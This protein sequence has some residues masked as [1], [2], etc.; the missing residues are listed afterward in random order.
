MSKQVAE[1]LK[2]LFQM[3]EMTRDDEVD[4][5]AVYDVMDE[6]AELASSG[7]DI[8]NLMPE[9]DDHLQR[10]KACKEELG[11]LQTIVAEATA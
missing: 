8:A 5:T 2:M 1:K 9:I 3:L 7:K 4:C 6:V 10:C 11:I